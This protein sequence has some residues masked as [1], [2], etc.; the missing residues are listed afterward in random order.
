MDDVILCR[1]QSQCVGSQDEA[2]AGGGRMSGSY[3]CAIMGGSEKRAKECTGALS[4][5]A[6]LE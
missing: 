2:S 6:V 1:S 5:Q 3:C 4:A